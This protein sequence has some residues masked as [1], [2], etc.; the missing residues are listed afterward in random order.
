M[1]LCYGLLVS[2]KIN[3]I[4]NLISLLDVNG[5]E[6]VIHVDLKK[7]DIYS[8][9]KKEYKSNKHIHFVENRI[10]S[11]WAHISETAAAVRLFE[12]VLEYVKDF[13]YFTI[14]SESCLP[15]YPDEEL[16]KFLEKNNG[17]EFIDARID[18]SKRS[19]L[20]LY[21]DKPTALQRKHRNFV[22][23][24][25]VIIDFLFG[26]IVGRKEFESWQVPYSVIWMTITKGLLE[27]LVNTIHKE[28][29]LEKYDNTLMQDEHIFA[30]VFMRSPYL[31]NQYI[32]GKRG[33][34]LHCIDWKVIN[35]PRVFTMKQYDKLYNPKT[36][37]F[38]A[39]KFD[40]NK[41]SEIIKKI[42]ENCK[43]KNFKSKF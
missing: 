3:Q 43:N 14:L 29:L 12:G 15:L 16:K 1:K 22:A 27:H 31:K 35:A 2:S 23:F 10:D 8:E 11:S 4:K 33:T 20:H 41:D 7:D 19:R 9:L 17:K 37:C 34:S 39:R 13:D 38:F 5:N 32:P 6:I 18:S 40:E 36:P 21:H 24:S 30:D 28:N 25:E 42:S 26:N